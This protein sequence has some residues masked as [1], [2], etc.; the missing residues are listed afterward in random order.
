MDALAVPLAVPLGGAPEHGFGG[1]VRKLR[2]RKEGCPNA[3]ESHC[4]A[5]FRIDPISSMQR[6]T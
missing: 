2:Q 4:N 5:F 6:C 3:R 1:L